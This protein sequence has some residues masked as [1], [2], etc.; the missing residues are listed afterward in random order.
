MKNNNFL[1]AKKLNNEEKT[2]VQQ[3]RMANKKAL[4]NN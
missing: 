3:K 4:Q 2:E 1:M